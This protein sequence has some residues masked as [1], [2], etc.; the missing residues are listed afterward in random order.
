M[1]RK[2]KRKARI[3]RRNSQNEVEVDVDAHTIRS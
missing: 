1:R 3:F 2:C